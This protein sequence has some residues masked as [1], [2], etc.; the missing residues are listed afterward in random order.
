MIK[1]SF[2]QFEVPRS[3]DFLLGIVDMRYV[4]LGTVFFYISST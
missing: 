4:D 1:C 3:S 2:K